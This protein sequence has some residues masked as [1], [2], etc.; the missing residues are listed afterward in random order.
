MEPLFVN[1]GFVNQHDGDLVPDRIKAVAGDTP[2][3]AA[4]GFEF[5]FRPAGGADEDF[6]QIRADS[7]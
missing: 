7:H 2:K 5:D 1:T 3:T 4:I 6:E